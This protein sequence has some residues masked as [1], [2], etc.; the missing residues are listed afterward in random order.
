[1][2]SDKNSL[3]YHPR[4]LICGDIKRENFAVPMSHGSNIIV[5]HPKLGSHTHKND[6]PEI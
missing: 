6:N 2:K 3:C 1:M 5:I 4:T